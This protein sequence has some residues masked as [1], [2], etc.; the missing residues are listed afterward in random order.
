[1]YV[2]PTAWEK[3]VLSMKPVVLVFFVWFCF[4][5]G[6]S[7]TVEGAVRGEGEVWHDVG[8]EVKD[9][10]YEG[11]EEPVLFRFVPSRLMFYPK[12]V[13]RISQCCMAMRNPLIS[14]RWTGK[15]A[16]FLKTLPDR[17]YACPLFCPN[18]PVLRLTRIG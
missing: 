14:P 5:V 16:L 9:T 7:G 18:K 10:L 1:M 4:V 6:L 2:I 8:A 13:I 3:K 17:G 12:S 15:T 11:V